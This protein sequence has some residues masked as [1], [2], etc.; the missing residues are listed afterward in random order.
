MFDADLHSIVLGRL[1][2]SANVCDLQ[3]DHRSLSW[4]LFRRRLH[5]CNDHLQFYKCLLV[6][7]GRTAKKEWKMTWNRGLLKYLSI[8]TWFK[9]SW[10]QIGT[11][12][13]WI[14]FR[15]ANCWNVIRFWFDVNRRKWQEMSCR[16][17]K[18]RTNFVTV[19]QGS[20]ILPG[21][22]D[23]RAFR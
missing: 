18:K 13:A 1:S 6:N 5:G 8:L 21:R 22:L 7:W 4:D 3:P 9:I 14:Y 10:H 17:L 2:P 19:S 20:V 15:S 23:G 11:E 12:T 16:T